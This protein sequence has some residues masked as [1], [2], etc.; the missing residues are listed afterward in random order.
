MAARAYVGISENAAPK[1][2]LY[3]FLICTTLQAAEL[4]LLCGIHIRS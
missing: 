1:I 4:G 2:H 3:I